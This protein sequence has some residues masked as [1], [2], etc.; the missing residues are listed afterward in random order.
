MIDAQR[1]SMESDAV[2]WNIEKETEAKKRANHEVDGEEKEPDNESVKLFGVQISKRRP[3]F[4]LF[5]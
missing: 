1:F 5:F 2:T 3:S 4:K